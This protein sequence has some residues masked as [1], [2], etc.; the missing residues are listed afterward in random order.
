[1]SENTHHS[2]GADVGTIGG[3]RTYKPNKRATSNR[4]LKRPGHWDQFSVL[5]DTQRANAFSLNL[6]Q[7]CFNSFRMVVSKFDNIKELLPT[8]SQWESTSVF[9]SHH[10]TKGQSK[11]TCHPADG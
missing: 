1:M 6:L 2:Q 10:S 4:R 9:F 11:F 7:K 5:L 3:I 8:D